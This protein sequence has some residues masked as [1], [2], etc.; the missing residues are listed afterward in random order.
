[1]ASQT[2]GHTAQGYWRNI[3][4]DEGET[5]IVPF[6]QQAI[7]WD[8]GGVSY[9]FTP[10]VADADIEVKAESS[11]DAEADDWT[12]DPTS[13][14]GDE[15]KRQG[16]TTRRCSR[17]RFTAVEGGVSIKILATSRFGPAEFS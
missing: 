6:D 5:A 2:D 10:R 9:T 12:E 11:L 1:M 15:K 17:K 8:L 7:K 3:L 16:S 4:L 13:P 14:Y